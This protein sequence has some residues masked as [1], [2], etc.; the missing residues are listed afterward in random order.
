MKRGQWDRFFLSFVRI[1]GTALPRYFIACGA[2]R[3]T[4]VRGSE[5]GASSTAA[6]SGVRLDVFEI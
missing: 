2:E 6:R 3:N 5:T 1:R 4:P